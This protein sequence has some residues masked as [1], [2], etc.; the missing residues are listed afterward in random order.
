MAMPLDRR[1]LIGASLSLPLLLR[2]A[3]SQAIPADAGECFATVAE[4]KLRGVRSSGLDVYRGVPYAGP[5]AGSG[6]FK[7]A[8]P[9]VAWSGVRD[10]SRLGPPSIQPPNGTYGIDEPAPDENCL[11]LNIWTPTGGTPG[12]PVMVYS[13]G[14][15]FTSGSAGSVL[16]DGGNLARDND[17][18]VVATNH[19]LGLLGFLYLDHLG[20]EDYAGSSNR[21][22]QDIAVALR[23]ISRNIAAF[24]GD[25]HNVMIFGESGGG[26]KTSCLYAM[27]QA[28]PLFTKASI[29][30]GP[31][32]HIMTPDL[33]IQTTDR[34]LAD[35]GLDRNSW[36]QLIEVP[37]AQLLAIQMRIGNPLNTAPPAWGGRKGL[38]GGTLGNFGAVLDG[39]VMPHHPFDPGAPAISRGKP[40]LV[41]GNEDEQMFFSQIAGDN[42]AWRLDDAALSSRMTSAFGPEVAD[43]IAAY[44]SDRPAA[45]PSDL[46]F[47][48]QSDLFSLQGS[49]LIAERKTRQ[50]GAPAYRYIFAF[51]Q[52]GPVRGAENLRM[53]AMHG[54]DIAFKF[55]NMDAAILNRPAFAGPRAERFAAGANMSR[56]WASFARTGVPVA[57]GQPKWPAYDLVNRPTMYIDAQCHV[58][59]DPYRAERLFW[60]KR[61]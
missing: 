19:R 8:P 14:G 4:G 27:P 47:A 49:T 2:P 9:P 44:R 28:A 30:S 17:V 38:A 20:G 6:R 5:V 16:Q 52:G 3:W 26:V 22:I 13:H 37:A 59:N 36:R 42:A 40:L 58:V 10:A 29:E 61:A 48:I 35:L 60:E 57:S 11:V 43:I 41:G 54:L 50:G 51:D 55:N 53:G 7:A 1:S 32:V 56:F 18:V 12:K 34:V 23:W 31:G 45:S 24:G 46:Y 25:P 21:G 39:Q 33:A 15:G